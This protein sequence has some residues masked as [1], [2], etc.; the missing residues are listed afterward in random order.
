MSASEIR[1]IAAL[2]VERWRNGGGVTRTIAS[3][4]SGECHWRISLAEVERNG[5]YSR[6]EGIA[7]QSLVLRGGGVVL[8]EKSTVVTLE[9]FEALEYDGDANWN[10]TLIDGPVTA[11]NVMTTKGR[12]RVSIRAIVEPLI[13]QPG[14][15]IAALALHGACAW[16]EPTGEA[17]GEIA[18]G[19]FL[20]TDCLDRAMRFSP[21]TPAAAPNNKHTEEQQFPVLVTIRS[22]GAH[23]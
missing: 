10:A 3:G 1:A 11:L 20:I 19:Q 15:P 12:Y 8:R 17:S 13:V 18:A 7:R 9:P 14:C 21:T 4:G 5:P 2:P 23:E 6:F 16:N 22:A